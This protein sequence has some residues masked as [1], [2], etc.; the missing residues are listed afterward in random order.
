MSG[1]QDLAAVLYRARVS[2]H[3]VLDPES[4]PDQRIAVQVE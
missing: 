4:S 1:E 3:S 2:E